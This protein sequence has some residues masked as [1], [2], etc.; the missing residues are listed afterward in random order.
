M[1]KASARSSEKQVMLKADSG[2]E[3][4]AKA[5]QKDTLPRQPTTWWHGRVTVR[6]PDSAFDSDSD[7]GLPPP[8]AVTCTMPGSDW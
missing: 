8:A 2:V 3:Y 5:S 7:T 1:A 6:K 4:K